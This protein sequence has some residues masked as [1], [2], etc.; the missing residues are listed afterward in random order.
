VAGRRT[1]AT[2]AHSASSTTVS[3]SPNEDPTTN[4]P[5]N[6]ATPPT[7]RAAQVGTAPSASSS[8]PSG[9]DRSGGTA[10]GAG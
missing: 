1:R 8:R 3:P 4:A 2:I 9:S 10:G 6:S 7:L 5:A